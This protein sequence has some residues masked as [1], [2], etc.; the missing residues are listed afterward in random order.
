MSALPAAPRERGTGCAQRRDPGSAQ[1]VNVAGAGA[2]RDFP[3]A[4]AGIEAKQSSVAASGFVEEVFDK[5]FSC[6]R[7]CCVTWA[8]TARSPFL[9]ERER[10]QGLRFVCACRSVRFWSPRRQL[11][12]GPHFYPFFSKIFASGGSSKTLT[13]SL[14]CRFLRAQLRHSLLCSVNRGLCG[15]WPAPELG[16]AGPGPGAL[17]C[18]CCVAAAGRGGVLHQRDHGALGRP[19]GRRLRRV[20]AGAG[21]VRTPVAHAGQESP[22]R[23]LAARRGALQSARS[24]HAA[25]IATAPVR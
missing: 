25:F 17:T 11:P 15:A 13:R 10:H 16:A 12:S 5:E 4:A 22:G 19:P 7:T 1:D 20:P 24:Q 3:C 2:C 9:G 18:L 21:R 8:Q 23:R 6:P 14:P